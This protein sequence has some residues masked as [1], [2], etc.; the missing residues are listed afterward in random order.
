LASN[1]HYFLGI[2]VA[3]NL[4][5]WLSGWQLPLKQMVSYKSWTNPKDLHI[6]LKF[7][8]AVSDEQITKLVEKLSTIQQAPFAIQVGSLNFFGKKSQPRVMWA[9]VEKTDDLKRLFDKVEEVCSELG[10][11]KENRPYTPHITLAKKWANERIHIETS[12]LKM[13]LMAPY[14]QNMNVNHFHLYRIY[15]QREVKYEPI[16]TVSLQ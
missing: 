4:Q 11:E 15:P 10:F 8:G 13:N 1:P 14:F 16:H 5:P 7:L 3:E 6:T 9:G 2:P 12:N